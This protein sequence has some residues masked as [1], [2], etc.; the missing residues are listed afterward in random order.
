MFQLVH[1]FGNVIHEGTKHECELVLKAFTT[2][3]IGDHKFDLIEKVEKHRMTESTRNE[4]RELLIDTLQDGM[5][6]DGM[7]ADY[8]ADGM[9]FKGVNNMTDSE[10]LEVMANIGYEED[11]L[12]IKAEAEMAVERMLSG[13]EL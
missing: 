7:E 8:V 2:Y 12:C 4:I 11:E 6:G 10:L 13:E 1:T 3:G 5:F 9:D